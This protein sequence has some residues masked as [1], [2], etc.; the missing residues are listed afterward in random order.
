LTGNGQGHQAKEKAVEKIVFAGA[1]CAVMSMG[2]APAVQAGEGTL[3]ASPVIVAEE[4]GTVERCLKWVEQKVTVLVNG[5]HETRT[6]AV[7][8]VRG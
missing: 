6:V 2:L 8:A 7:C 1:L 4:K 3:R 5:K